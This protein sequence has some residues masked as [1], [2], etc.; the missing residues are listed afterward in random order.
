MILHTCNVSSEH[1]AFRDCLA[2]VTTGDALLLIG[3]AVYAARDGSQ[4]CGQLLETAAELYVLADDAD[5]RGV[6]G[7]LCAAVTSL[8]MAG[9]VAL[10]ERFPRIQAWY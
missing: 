6:S 4:A 1:T 10:T 3:D 7:Y 9:F 5:A 8:E 2:V